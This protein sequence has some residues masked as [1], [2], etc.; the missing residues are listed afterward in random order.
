[1]GKL[2]NSLLVA[3]L[4]L[5]TMSANAHQP[6]ISS[7]VLIEQ[8][9]GQWRVQVNASLTAFQ[10]E[11]KN[12]YGNDSYASPEDFNGLLL[13]HLREQINL[14]VNNEKM[15]LKNGF[16][17]LGHATTVVFELRGVPAVIKKLWIGNEGFKNIHHSQSVFSIKREG[18]DKVQFIL[19][20]GNNFQTQLSFQNN[21]VVLLEASWIDDSVS[22]GIIVVSVVLLGFLYYKTS[23]RKLNLAPKSLNRV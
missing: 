8:D 10:Y 12:A 23:F 20:E 14:R 16:V 4:W 22:I 6:D 17:K 13:D 5:S 1:M 7:I 21:Q 3:M 11:V 18:L 15:E 9:S 2:S 19:N